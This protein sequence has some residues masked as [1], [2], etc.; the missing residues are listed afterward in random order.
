MPARSPAS[1]LQK[2]GT[3]LSI[4]SGELKAIENLMHPDGDSVAVVDLF[5]PIVESCSGFGIRGSFESRV[6]TLSACAREK[7]SS[8]IIGS[9]TSGS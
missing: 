1:G 8:Y 4:S 3:S 6:T 7:K 5:R 9:A 2:L